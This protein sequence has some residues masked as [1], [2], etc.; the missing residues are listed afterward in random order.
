MPRD[1]SSRDSPATR[2]RR[3]SRHKPAGI[4]E[5]P[6]QSASGL[7]R[8]QPTGAAVLDREILSALARTSVDEIGDGVI[9]VDRDAAASKHITGDFSSAAAG[10]ARAKPAIRQTPI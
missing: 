7:A 6:P 5:G 3:S 8:E 1:R 4:F 10:S 2:H 9:A